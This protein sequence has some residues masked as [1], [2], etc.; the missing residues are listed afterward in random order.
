MCTIISV[1]SLER[2]IEESITNKIIEEENKI[3]NSPKE[4]KKGKEKEHRISWTNRKQ[5]VRW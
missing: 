5:I 1:R 3:K 2:I 4:G